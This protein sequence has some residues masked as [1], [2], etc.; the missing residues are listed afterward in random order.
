[1]SRLAVPLIA[2]VLLTTT[3]WQP[4]VRAQARTDPTASEGFTLALTGDSVITRRLSVYNEPEFRA[5][6]RAAS[7]RRR[8]VYEPRDAVPQL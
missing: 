1:M 4:H 6:D 5:D 8:G 7:R 2:V 3:G